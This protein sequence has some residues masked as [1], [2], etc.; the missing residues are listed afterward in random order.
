MRQQRRNATYS[1]TEPEVGLHV[2]F[3]GVARRTIAAEPSLE[4]F[5][6]AQRD[7]DD[8][9]VPPQRLG[10][11]AVGPELRHHAG[12]ISAG[13]A[14]GRVPLFGDRIETVARAVCTRG[15]YK[16]RQKARPTGISDAVGVARRRA[17]GCG[18]RTKPTTT[19]QWELR[20]RGAADPSRLRPTPPL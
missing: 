2:P 19:T 6:R 4:S 13:R 20:V 12:A 7:E 10:V 16:A 15:P 9:P 14:P 5:V 18:F 17:A 1:A 11:V 3:Q 8:E